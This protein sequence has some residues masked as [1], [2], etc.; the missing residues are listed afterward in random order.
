M[1]TLQTQL[2]FSDFD[3]DVSEKSALHGVTAIFGP[4]GSGKSTLLR[5]IAGFETP[6]SGRIAFN[7]Q[8]W[9]DDEANINVASHRRPIGMMF[10]D[11]RLFTHLD[12]ADNLSF[13]EKRQRPSATVD[14]DRIIAA[15]DVEPLLERQSGTLSGGEGRR[16]A[17]ARTLLTGPELLLLDEPLSGL[18]RDRKAEI[19]PYL[20]EVPRDFGIP[21]LYVSHDIDE[22]AHI[23]DQVLVLAK[24]RIQSRGS[25]DEIVERLDLE[26]TVGRFDAGVLLKGRITQH[27]PRL[28][29]TYVDLQGDTLTMPLLDRLPPGRDIRIRVRARDV[30]IATKRPEGLSIRNILPGKI[31]EVIRD[32]SSGLVHVDVQLRGAKV[33]ARLTRAAVEDLQLARGSDVFALIKSVSFDRAG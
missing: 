31:T 4:S 23:A 20:E 11:T 28:H 30:A 15:L 32:A 13:A 2:R 21:T 26:T 1:L 5:C 19:L 25:T 8:T 6:T 22:I 16:V 17:L 3:L 18:D 12:V 24:G 9:F 7:N 10:Q 27:D 29:L 33:R 14:R